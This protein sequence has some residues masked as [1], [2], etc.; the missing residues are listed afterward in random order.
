MDFSNFF[1]P[2]DEKHVKR[3]KQ[4]AKDLRKSP[5]WKNRLGEGKCHYCQERFHPKELTMDHVTPIIRG[6]FTNKNNCVACC[7]E[8]NNQK[9]YLLPVEW[10]GYLDKLKKDS[11]NKL[12]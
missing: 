3:E 1:T 6:G 4:K 2:A 11:E 9:K 8:C 12:R 10:Q 5:W 7:K